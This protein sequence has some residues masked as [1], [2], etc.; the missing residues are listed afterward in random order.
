MCFVFY[1]Y[2]PFLQTLPWSTSFLD[3][4]NFVSFCSLRISYSA[5]PDNIGCVTFHWNLTSIPMAAP[6]EK[7]TNSYQVLRLEKEYYTQLFSPHWDTVWFAF[8]EVFHM[9]SQPMFSRLNYFLVVIYFWHILFLAFPGTLEEEIW[10][11]F[12]L[13]M[14][15][16]QCFI[17]C[18]LASCGVGLCVNNHL[19]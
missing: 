1:L 11:I 3:L 5:A 12:H 19:I 6:L 2:S 17:L 7:I 18:V 14:K 15:I 10:Q 4:P 16:L 9:L 8:K 13:G